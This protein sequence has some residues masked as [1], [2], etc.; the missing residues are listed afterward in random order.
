MGTFAMPLVRALVAALLLAG[1]AAVPRNPGPMRPQGPRT[2][3]L[4]DGCLQIP[5]N[6]CLQNGQQQITQQPSDKDLSLDLT[7]DDKMGHDYSGHDN[8]LSSPHTPG[9]AQFGQGNSAF[10]DGNTGLKIKNGNAFGSRATTI[11]F[12]IFLLEDSKGAWRSVVSRGSGPNDHTPEIM[13]WPKERRVHARVSTDASV[14][15]GLDSATKL[16]LKR[17]T[18][19]AYVCEGKLL[20]LFINGV[21]D[22]EVILKGTPVSNN[23]TISIGKDAHHAGTKC[24]IDT[25]KWYSRALDDKEVRLLADGSLPGVGPQF[26]QLGCKTCDF[27]T[28]LTSCNEGYHI[29]TTRELYASAFKVAGGMGWLEINNQVWSRNSTTASPKSDKRLGLCCADN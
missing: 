5:S 23:G 21:K 13:L 10:L 15:E 25:F 22:S 3:S 6:V 9:P 26:V 4:N 17:W 12:W 11:A 29:C 8:H 24:F 18:H 16:K 7:F 1:A 27:E 28:A 14:N 19:I 20:Q 2:N